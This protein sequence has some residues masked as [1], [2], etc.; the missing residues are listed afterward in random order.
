M[1]GILHK[2]EYNEWLVT[3]QDIFQL[4]PDDANELFELE[5][6]FDNLEARIRIQPIV[7]FDV[8]EYKKL[9]GIIKYAKL[10][11]NEIH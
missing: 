8:V 4:H 10:I 11:K 1:K 7:E 3:C 5:Q 6:I 9:T 2:G